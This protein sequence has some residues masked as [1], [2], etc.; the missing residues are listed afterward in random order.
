MIK[1]FSRD[2]AQHAVMVR[3]GKLGRQLVS[4]IVFISLVVAVAVNTVVA[5]VVA[6][7]ACARCACV[8]VFQ[9]DFLPASV[10]E[11]IERGARGELGCLRRRPSDEGSSGLGLGALIHG[12]R[13]NDAP[14]AEPVGDD[15]E[16]W[17]GGDC[18]VTVDSM[19]SVRSGAF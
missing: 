16:G 10:A 12:R 8:R 7:A 18:L 6:A 17:G 19:T 5:V 2:S 11:R 15:V 3:A 14:G 9:K 1:I 4:C 13:R